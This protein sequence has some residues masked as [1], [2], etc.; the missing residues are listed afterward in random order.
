M[1]KAGF[2]K[3]DFVEKEEDVLRFAKF[4][5]GLG[6]HNEEIAAQM[7]FEVNLAIK[8]ENGNSQR[9]QKSQTQGRKNIKEILINTRLR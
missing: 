5:R 7:E 8:E 4:A 2:L 6:F 9:N 3:P 1:K